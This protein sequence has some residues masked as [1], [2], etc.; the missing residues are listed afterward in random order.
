MAYSQ[1]SHHRLIDEIA[2]VA[3]PQFL[4]V[5][6]ILPRS[7]LNPYA[8]PTFYR[9]DM[10]DVTIIPGHDWVIN[11]SIC[12]DLGIPSLI[13]HNAILSQVQKHHQT[14]SYANRLVR[15]A[16]PKDIKAVQESYARHASSTNFTPAH[17]TEPQ[18]N[19]PKSSTV[20]H[21]ISK[22]SSEGLILCIQHV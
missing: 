5:D 17:G 22:T 11:L 12:V 20:Q 13:I 3:S 9:T 1:D 18:H 6:S 4:I 7:K 16:L 8:I 14:A 2:K 19:D 10:P 15:Q 21:K